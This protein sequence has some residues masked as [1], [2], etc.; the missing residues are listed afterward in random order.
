MVVSAKASTAFLSAA[1]GADALLRTKPQF[2]LG[3]WV[4][5]AQSWAE[6]SPSTQGICAASGHG[7]PCGDESVSMHDCE[8]MMCCYDVETGKC[9]EAESSDY[10]LFE[11]NAKTL[12]TLWGPYDTHLHDYSYRWW[13]DL[14]GSF[15]VPR[16]TQWFHGQRKAL[17]AGKPYDQPAFDRSI[18]LWEESWVLSPSNFTTETSGDAVEISEALLKSLFV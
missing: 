1:R 7:N 9:F 5:S 4:A 14:V 12:V 10:L 8:L 18:E 6:T 11:L 16:W 15:Y 17:A 2:L 13:A 3:N